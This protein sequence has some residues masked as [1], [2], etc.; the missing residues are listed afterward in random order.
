MD[1]I[2]PVFI[3]GLAQEI[4]HNITEAARSRKMKKESG[5]RG[6]FADRMV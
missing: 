6:G 4:I 3:S 1:V 5:K 2:L